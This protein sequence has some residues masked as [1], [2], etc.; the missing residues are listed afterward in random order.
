MGFTQRL[1]QLDAFKVFGNFMIP[2]LDNKSG[3]NFYS[4]YFGSVPGFIFTLAALIISTAY[5]I[6]TLIEMQTGKLDAYSTSDNDFSDN[7]I[8]AKFIDLNGL[9]NTGHIGAFPIIIFKPFN[10]AAF[11]KYDFDIFLD[12]DVKLS[13]DTNHI[14]VDANKL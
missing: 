5:L 8:E 14:L 6:P 7:K 10:N 2:K 1:R 4:I 12:D 13:G 3:N 9:N 11:L